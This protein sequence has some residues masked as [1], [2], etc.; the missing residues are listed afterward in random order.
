MKAS[1][2]SD[3]CDSRKRRNASASRSSRSFAHPSATNARA[4]AANAAGNSASIR[5]FSIPFKLP[6]LRGFS[7]ERREQPGDVAPASAPTT[8][9]TQRHSGNA[10]TNRLFPALGVISGVSRMNPDAVP[11]VPVL[12]A[13]YCRPSTA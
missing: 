6:R 11:A 3:A 8:T 7:V 4:C 9:A 1:V 13:T 12:T 5:T 2:N 10:N